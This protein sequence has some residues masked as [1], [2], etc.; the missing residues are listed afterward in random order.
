MT[1]PPPRSPAR[2]VRCARAFCP[3]PLSRGGPSFPRPRPFPIPCWP[4]IVVGGPSS[5]PSPSSAF[6]GRARL[7]RPMLCGAGL[8]C[9]RR[10]CR[11]CHRPCGSRSRRSRC[12]LF[13]PAIAFVP[14]IAV[15]PVVV[16]VFLVLFVRCLCWAFPVSR[17]A[18]V[19]V[20]RW[21]RLACL[22][23]YPGLPVPV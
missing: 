7:S 15:G 1:R 18:G 5:F 23:R 16:V 4:L 22:P 13:V 8:P 20:D 9:P 14:V 19:L 3:P 12:L 17:G 10:S 11:L 6:L 2:Q 21:R